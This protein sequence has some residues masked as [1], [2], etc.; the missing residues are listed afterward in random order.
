VGGGGTLGPVAEPTVGILSPGTMGSAIGAVLRGHGV[1]VLTSLEG[2]GEGTRRRAAAA[3]FVDVGSVEELVRAADVLLSVL[4]PAAALETG[5]RVADALRTTG[6][7]LLF[8]ECN[9]VAPRTARAIAEAVTAAG[10]RFADAG[11]FGP[12]PGGPHATPIYTSGPGAAEF[13]ELRAYGLDVRVLPG[14]VGQASALEMCAGGIL[15]GF[16]ALAAGLLVAAR[17]WEVGPELSSV[18]EGGA[19]ELL[20]YLERAAPG[21]PPRAGRYGGEMPEVVAFLEDL[22]LPSGAFRA[23]AELYGSVG[24]RLAERAP[25]SLERLID[26]LDLG[27]PR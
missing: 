17:R 3:G 21:L 16:Q 19:P 23:A 18:L 5:T 1:P 22:D 11:I 14:P 9:F 27:G 10:G 2:R 8:V 13:A 26:D 7:D 12:P 20:R 15:K 6:A 4:S 25:A 24:G